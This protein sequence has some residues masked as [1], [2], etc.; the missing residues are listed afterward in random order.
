MTSCCSLRGAHDAHQPARMLQLQAVG[1]TC[2]CQWAHVRL[3]HGCLGLHDRLEAGELQIPCECNHTAHLN[4]R[5]QHCCPCQRQLEAGQAAVHSCCQQAGSSCLLCHKCIQWSCTGC[6]GWLLLQGLVQHLGLAACQG[7][8]QL[9]QGCQL[10]CPGCSVKGAG[11]PLQGGPHPVW[12]VSDHENGQELAR[13]HLGKGA[14][15]KCAAVPENRSVTSHAAFTTSL[16]ADQAP[17][18]QRSRQPLCHRQL[19]TAEAAQQAEDGSLCT[20]SNAAERP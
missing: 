14:H 16:Q 2:C 12:S 20:C 4:C 19:C 10:G 13:A 6:A 5:R 9:H 1:P 15:K 7:V 17:Q 18:R 11:S 8:P 3:L